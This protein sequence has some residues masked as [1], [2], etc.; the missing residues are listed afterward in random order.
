MDR[1]ENKAAH[2]QSLQIKI[3]SRS[4]LEQRDRFRAIENLFYDWHTESAGRLQLTDNVQSQLNGNWLF[5]SWLAFVYKL[6]E[7]KSL[8]IK[9]QRAEQLDLAHVRVC[10]WVSVCNRS[11]FHSVSFWVRRSRFTPALNRAKQP[12]AEQ[13]QQHIHAV[14]IYTIRL[15]FCRILLFLVNAIL[16]FHSPSFSIFLYAIS[17]L[18]NGDSIWLNI[19]NSDHEAELQL[20]E[21]IR[22]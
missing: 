1:R 19:L 2:K 12:Y 20:V 13:K 5:P 10:V 18:I 22:L 7:M 11:R 6:T 14:L 15:M 16:P 9:Y 8:Q 4:M 21:R 3:P 17:I